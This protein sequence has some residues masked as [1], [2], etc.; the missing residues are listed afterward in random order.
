MK[1]ILSLLSILLALTV[2]LCACAQEPTPTTVPTTEPTTASTT[3]PTTA[4]TTEP[5]TEP[6]SEP[7]TEAT[8]PD[9]ATP[10]EGP[11]QDG[12]RLTE[13]ELAEFEQMFTRFDDEFSYSPVNY[14][15][16]ALSQKYESV[17]EMVIGYFFN[18]GFSDVWSAELTQAEID[19]YCKELG[20]EVEKDIY[21]FPAD[22]VG[23]ILDYYLGRTPEELDMGMVY[24][25]NTDCYYLS[26][27]GV[28][29]IPTMYIHFHDGYYDQETGLISLYYNS[30]M[31]PE[32][33]VITLQSK[34]SIG[35]AGYYIVSNVVVRS[36][37]D[38][39]D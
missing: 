11:R 38:S 32:E 24:N 23:W 2:L 34:K 21:R 7:T 10:P 9:P 15:N 26:P 20:Y 22:K 33:L 25:P 17:D 13:E 31:F 3:E 8:E 35:E 4:P 37:W 30:Y 5:T 39:M 29:S 27:G 36:W 12:Q 19:F 1:K 28:M 18:D 16:L 14:Y 6:T